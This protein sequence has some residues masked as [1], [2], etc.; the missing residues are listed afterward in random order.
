MNRK[1]KVFRIFSFCFCPFPLSL[2]FLKWHLHRN[3]LHV[4]RIRIQAHNQSSVIFVG[5][6]TFFSAALCLSSIVFFSL[7]FFI[8]KSNATFL[9][10][11][12]VWI[13]SKIKK[14][15]KIF[16]FLLVCVSRFLFH[17][18]ISKAIWMLPF[19]LF[20]AYRTTRTFVFLP[21][22]LLGLL[23]YL[24]GCLLY[25]FSFFILHTYNL[26][27]T[28]KRVKGSNFPA[29]HSMCDCRSMMMVLEIGLWFVVKWIGNRTYA[30]FHWDFFTLKHRNKAI[31]NK[32]INA[33]ALLTK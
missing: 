20:I 17:L 11:V 4:L 30:H 24:F 10:S 33:K 25:R 5:I 22:F 1:I 15:K 12:Y 32:T 14:K 9:V 6:F 8:S 23:F 27:R 28:E 26:F 31:I 3:S 13:K 2:F 19:F 18:C 21:L 16:L 29:M 7:F